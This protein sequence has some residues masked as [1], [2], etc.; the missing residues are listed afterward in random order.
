MIAHRRLIRSVAGV[1]QPRFMITSKIGLD[2]VV[3]H[4]IPKLLDPAGH[5]V[6]VLVAVNGKGSTAR[7]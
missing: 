2:E 1:I 3:S 7:L 5:E 6:K 4:G